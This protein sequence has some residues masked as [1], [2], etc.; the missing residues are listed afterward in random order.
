MDRRQ[1]ATLGVERNTGNI[2]GQR[3]LNEIQEIPKDK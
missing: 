2:K 3:G 1:R